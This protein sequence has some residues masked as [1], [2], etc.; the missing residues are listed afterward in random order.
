MRHQ[1]IGETIR[2][3]RRVTRPRRFGED[4]RRSG[5]LVEFDRT[6]TMFTKPKDPRT[7]GYVTG[8]FG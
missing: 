2:R 8:R 7:E 4:G 5:V 3:R 1:H 6:S